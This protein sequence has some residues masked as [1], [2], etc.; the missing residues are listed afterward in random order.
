MMLKAIGISERELE[1]IQ[2]G[3][4]AK[5]GFSEK[6]VMLI[7]LARAANSEPHNINAL[8]FNELRDLGTTDAEIVEALAVMGIFTSLNKFIDALEVAPEI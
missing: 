3:A 2:G 5:A 6:E 7:G 4:L 1:N 8:L